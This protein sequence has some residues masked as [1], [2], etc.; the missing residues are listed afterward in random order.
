MRAQQINVPPNP[1]SASD[2]IARVIQPS[3]A[4][5]AAIIHLFKH[6]DATGDGKLNTDDIQGGNPEGAAKFFEV[7]RYDQNGDQG[8]QCNG[9]SVTEVLQV[10]CQHSVQS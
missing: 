3:P 8:E 4:N 6:L 10:A 2:K 5:R 9:C 1:I 7:L